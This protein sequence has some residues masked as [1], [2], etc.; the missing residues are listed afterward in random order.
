MDDKERR[1]IITRVEAGNDQTEQNLLEMIRDNPALIMVGMKKIQIGL[2]KAA[3]G[4]KSLL[5]TFLYMLLA[6]GMTKLVSAQ[7]NMLDAILEERGEGDADPQEDN[8]G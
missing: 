5:G 7:A 3:E 4:E 1:R 8:P 2:D 6:Y